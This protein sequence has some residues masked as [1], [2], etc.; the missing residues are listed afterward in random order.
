MPLKP[1]TLTPVPAQLV[2]SMAGVTNCDM[3]LIDADDVHQARIRRRW[4]TARR[5][6]C[7]YPISG[8]GTLTKEYL[9]FPA[10]VG[11]ELGRDAVTHRPSW[12]RSRPKRRPARGPSCLVMTQSAAA[13]RPSCSRWEGCS[14]RSARRLARDPRG[15]ETTRIPAA[16]LVDL[17]LQRVGVWAGGPGRSGRPSW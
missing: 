9:I 7:R 13:G 12:R 5:A 1:M 10:A 14:R 16:C 6:F 3:L 15:H 11:V 2:A 4:P 17:R 8:I